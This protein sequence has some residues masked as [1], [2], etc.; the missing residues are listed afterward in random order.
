[1]G[2]RGMSARR[3]SMSRAAKRYLKDKKRK[4]KLGI[5]KKKPALS[6]KALWILVIAAL[7]VFGLVMALIARPIGEALT[8]T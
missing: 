6:R 4:K 5:P 7:I 2:R 8:R 1:M 3:L